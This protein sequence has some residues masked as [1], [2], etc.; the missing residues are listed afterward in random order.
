[1]PLQASEVVAELVS[2]ARKAQKQYEKYNQE[3]VDRVVTAT[4]WALI[5]PEHNEMLAQL[6]VEETGLGNVADKITKNHRKTLGLLRDLRGAKT[7]GVISEDSELGLIEIARPVGVV[8]VIVP[9]TNPIATPMN[10]TLNALKCRN[11]I[12]LAPSPKGQPSCARLVKLIHHELDRIGAPRDLVQHLPS[13]VSK[14]LSFEMLAQVDHVIA[15]GSQNNVR[16]AYTSGT[17]AFGV[18]AGNVTVIVDETADLAD[19]AAKIKASKTFDNATSCSSENSLVIVD[20]IYDQMI[21]QLS[22]VGAALLDSK[23]KDQLQQNMWHNGHLNPKMLAKPTSAICQAA[24]LNRE[25]LQNAAFLM[26][27][28][29]R[30]GE[31]A[32]FSGEK[33]ALVLTIYRAKDFGHATEIAEQILS[34][35]GKGHSLGIH[36]DNKERALT[37]GLNMPVCRII[38]NQ[39]HCFAT[40]GSF[41]NSLPF[42]LS[43][44]C[45]SWGGNITDQNLH[46]RQYMNVTKVVKSI[47][48]REISVETL[49]ADYKREFEL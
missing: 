9:S 33:M 1:M 13:P 22:N 43:M 8:G 47:A 21:E 29:S 48:P 40:G 6:A 27:E 12:I 5:N 46:Y 35:M 2:K 36:T 10:N 32:P 44:G 4:A 45:G 28:E 3:Q 7:V 42:S 26:V 14:A 23:E 16:A 18:G 41:D 17:P 11:A 25:A 49:F 37:L 19:A 15:T 38:V 39:A 30:A 31:H 34:Y 20:A 24:Q